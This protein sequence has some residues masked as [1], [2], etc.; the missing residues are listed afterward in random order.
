[1]V[2][3][4]WK[5]MKQ[6]KNNNTAKLL[7]KLAKQTIQKRNNALNLKKTVQSK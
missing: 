6:T 5:I 4:T 1:M 2:Y 7:E 3:S